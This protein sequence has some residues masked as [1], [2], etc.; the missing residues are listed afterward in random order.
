MNASVYECAYELKS[1]FPCAPACINVCECSVGSCTF[2]KTICSVL[3]IESFHDTIFTPWHWNSV[4]YD[5]PW[6]RNNRNISRSFLFCSFRHLSGPEPDQYWMFKDDTDTNSWEFDLL[7]TVFLLESE[8]IK[9]TTLLL[10]AVDF[11]GSWLA[12]WRILE[13]TP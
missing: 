10:S 7:S 5:F 1:V 3:H 4:E 6:I 8:S 13:E 11:I 9:Y 2:R 12:Y